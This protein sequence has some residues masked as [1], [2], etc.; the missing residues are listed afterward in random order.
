MNST[1][2]ILETGVKV[3]DFFTPFLKGGKIGIFG[4]A[5]VGKTIILTE[6]IHNVA[7]FHKGI[8]VFAG[9]GE[10]IREAQ[11]MVQNL[12]DNKVIGNVALVFGQM[13]ERPAVRFRTGYA[14]AT[15]AEYFRDEEDRDILFFV[16]NAYRFI[17]AGNE[18]S[19]LLNTIPSEDGYQAT[20]TSDIGIFQERLV[21]AGRGNITSVEAVYV[22][23]DDFTDS[24]VQ[25][26]V[27]YFD[28]LIVLSRAVSEEG[29]RPSVDIL[30]SSSGLIEPH[31]LG[32][33]HY[34][35]YLEAE[36]ILNRFAYL[37]RIVSIA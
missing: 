30:A 1:R 12:T 26:L 8:S 15:I 5:G 24:G 36:K 29:R 37:D 25:A 27:P 35:A 17:Q 22:P 28:A 18:L 14:A 34:D 31:L 11:E 19:T 20:L 32:R 16:D 6:L 4:G 33:E 23:A 10:R 7:I 2:E 13:N 21:S 3:V 9:I